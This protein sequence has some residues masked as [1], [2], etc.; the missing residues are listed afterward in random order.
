VLLGYRRSVVLGRGLGVF[1][2]RLYCW[3]TWQPLS[4]P[5]EKIHVAIDET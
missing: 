4:V 5:R 2:V 1:V 3:V